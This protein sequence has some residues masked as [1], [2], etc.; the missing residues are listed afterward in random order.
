MEPFQDSPAKL[1]PDPM[2]PAANGEMV[3]ATYRNG[4]LLQFQSDSI[5]AQQPYE[6]LV[7]SVNGVL[8]EV[9]VKTFRFT[10]VSP[11]AERLL[12]YPVEEWLE[13]DFWVNHVYPPDLAEA[14]DFC[15][16]ATQAKQNHQFEYRMVAADGRLVWI[17][18]IVTVVVEHDQPVLLRGVLLDISHQKQTEQALREHQVQLDLALAIAEMGTW[19]WD[20]ATNQVT[21]SGYIQAVFGQPQDAARPTYES[22]IDNIYADDR[23]YVIQSVNQAIHE[24]AD[25]HV[26][27]RVRWSDGSLRW[28]SCRGQVIRN[29]LGT[30]LRMVG[31]AMDITRQKQSEQ[32]LRRSRNFL[33]TLL[34]RLPVAVFVKDGRQQHF[35]KFTFWNKTAEHLFGFTA[36]QMIGNTAHAY[37]PAE[38]AAM[39]EQ[40]DQEIFA[41][42]DP[43]TILETSTQAEA[44]A[45]KYLKT[46][47]IPVFDE[48]HNPEYLL[49]ISE[50]ITEHQQTEEALRQQVER[51]ELMAAIAQEIR[52]SLDL[53]QILNTTVAQV[54]Q[55]LQ[56]DRVLIVRFRSSWASNVLVES[57]AAPWESILG[58]TYP[59]PCFP[60]VSADFYKQGQIQAIANLADAALPDCYQTMMQDLQVQAVLTIPIL[61]N[62]ELWG[63][64]IA[65]HCTAP[66]QWQPFEIDILNQLAAQVSVAIE[67]SELY[68]QV[69][70]LNADL[71]R[72]VQ[73]RTAELQLASDFEATLKRITDRVR[74]SLDEDQILQTAVRELAMAIGVTN[75]N[76]AIYDLETR[77]SKVSYEYTDSLVPLQ[78]R[79]VQM[80]NF[81]EGYQ[82]L[83]RGL[84]FQF[85]SLV[86]NP[87]RG[88]VA[89]LACPIVDDQGV[90]GDLW[91]V[92]Q[93][94]R[95]FNDQ[96]IRLVQQVA[97]QCAI[98]IRQARL[99]QAAQAQVEALE[100]LNGLKDD[101]LSTVSHELRTP[102]S[103]IKMATQMLEILLFQ[104]NGSDRSQ[105]NPSSTPPA[106]PIT[107]SSPAALEKVGRYFQILKDE[108]RREINLIN[109]LLDLSRLDTGADLPNLETVDLQS[110]LPKLVQPFLIRATN[111]QQTLTVH[112]PPTNPLPVTTDFSRLDRIVG[113]LLNNACKYTPAREHITLS[114][115]IKIKPIADPTNSALPNPSL[116]EIVVSNSG[117]EIASSELTRIFERFYRVPN[118]DPWKHGGTGL[119]LALA[120]K[121]LEPLQG[122]LWATSQN[123]L[124]SFTVELPLNLPLNGATGNGA[125]GNNQ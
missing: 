26:E 77:T 37:Y 95:S 54:R 19:D 91:L 66:R 56:T 79:V 119:G 5:E 6:A 46:T 2:T 85:C 104:H 44:Q 65:H 125:A 70:R 14:M 74:D 10:F 40:K 30:P 92:S 49:C 15:I 25:Y 124:T 9:E 101:F 36:K 116:L 103:N 63:L 82:Q 20:L 45:P 107:F 72:Q 93:K 111:Q 48:Q 102:M 28:L 8:W 115:Q 123:G 105:Q 100:K 4:Y 1:N 11:Q 59:D 23:P 43:A 90:L 18:D 21:Y 75:C 108:C 67:Q 22:F 122:K 17:Q 32:E 53:K 50:D 62:G 13:A 31:V 88:H 3:A 24:N 29:E 80:D 86:P 12:G 109:D 89:M 110:W 52:Q 87:V 113:E 83:L 81:A 27:F 78:G 39:F 47:K 76:A 16:A 96:D 55:F 106:P 120:K 7:N 51:E 99:Y 112:L 71:E 117:V 42:G 41:Q 35:G 64:L 84:Y 68:Q 61:Q 73:V 58:N 94:Y 38:Q 98:A 60:K 121:L 33:K 57:V 34:N 118:N 114:A 97:N 69:Q